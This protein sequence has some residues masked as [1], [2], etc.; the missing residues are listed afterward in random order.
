MTQLKTKS[1]FWHRRDLRI[2]D[3]KGLY[4]A[5]ENSDVVQPIFI[6]DSTILQQLPSDDKRVNFIY[7][8]VQKLKTAYLDLESDLLVY[9][10]NPVE[11]IPQIASE[12]DVQKI[13]FNND[14]E[15]KAI[16]RDQTLEAILKQ[17]KID[18]KGCK[19]HVI[20]EKNE[21]LKP[22][23]SP[24]TIFTPYSKKWKEKLKDE[25]L[26]NY[27]IESYSFK[28]MNK[29]NNNELISIE[30]IGFRNSINLDSITPKIEDLNI[31]NYH[32]DRDYPSKNAT[33]RLSVHLRFG[34]ISIRQ[35][36]RKAKTQNDV[37]LNELI[38]REFYQMILFHF[39]DS[40]HKSFK[41]NYENIPW[42]N[43]EVQFKLWCEGKTGYPI[44]D[45]GM[46]E[47]NETGFMHNRVRMIVASFLIKHLLI[48]WRWGETYFAEKLLDYEQA[49]NVGGW[50]WAASSGCDAVPYF[51]I[52]NPISQQVKFD[53]KLEYIQKWIP[54]YGTEKYPKPIVDHKEA[55]EKVLNLYKLVLSN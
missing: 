37:F 45:A 28:L 26:K 24:Y 14:Y 1:I 47:L 52:F 53:G 39:P 5:L 40:V 3:N 50:Q 16:L 19:D 36:V 29:N 44:V 10:G 46:R 4:Y 55:R 35:L 2:T 49:S 25:D 9:F 32:L 12:L 33:S 31:E 54:E 43:N 38:W 18:F 7:Q 11:I 15:P 22:N 48:D 23:N 13:I 42:K 6:F 21:L 30:K 34:T 20:F 27:N 51:R 41:K 8:A 17:R